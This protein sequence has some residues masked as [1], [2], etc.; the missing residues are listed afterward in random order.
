ELVFTVRASANKI[1]PMPV[2]GS[3]PYI[4]DYGDGTVA[5]EV[6]LRAPGY[7]QYPGSYHTYSA[8]GEYTV[9][10][11]GPAATAFHLEVHVTVI[12]SIQIPVRQSLF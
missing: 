7:T 2:L 3:G 5:Q 9:T 11:K 12:F 10:I 8:D 4:I 6:D 1:V